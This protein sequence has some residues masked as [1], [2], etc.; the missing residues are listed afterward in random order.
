MAKI[1]WDYTARNMYKVL[2]QLLAP[3]HLARTEYRKLK[4]SGYTE[5]QY[6]R[7]NSKLIP[8][9]NAQPGS[10]IITQPA[11]QINAQQGSNS[12][13]TIQSNALPPSQTR[14]TIA[15]G[16]HR[17][18]LASRYA[19]KVMKDP[20]RLHS[21]GQLQPDAPSFYKLAFNDALVG[22]M[23]GEPTLRTV[24]GNTVNIIVPAT[25][26]VGVTQ[27]E[28]VLTDAQ[29]QVLAEGNG[30]KS[31]YR[32][33]WTCKTRCT[34]EQLAGAQLFI[35]ASDLAGNQAIIRKTL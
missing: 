24:F 15:G 11:S 21:Y 22:P 13:S 7:S 6:S 20:D 32:E 8:A 17:F 31:K 5:K 34:M 29:K 27:V 25:D 3:L 14:V 4:K 26:N 30:T 28:F 35:K 18:K 19:Q 10:S 16:E 33:E 9:S 2:M 1:Q 23:L 12:L